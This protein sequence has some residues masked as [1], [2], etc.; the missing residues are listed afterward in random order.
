MFVF[1][2]VDF[3]KIKGPISLPKKKLRNLFWGQVGPVFEKTSVYLTSG[4]C[5]GLE[6]QNDPASGGEDQLVVSAHLEKKIVKLD[7][8]PGKGENKKS[9]KPPPRRALMVNI[10]V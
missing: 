5:S 6:G 3:P 9:L 1:R 2:G 10:I 4:M 8:F 7:H